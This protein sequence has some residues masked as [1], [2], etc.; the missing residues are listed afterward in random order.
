MFS[1]KFQ[2]DLLHILTTIKN[3][4]REM[5]VVKKIN[6]KKSVYLILRLKIMLVT[7]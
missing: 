5:D 7:K 1:K 6:K 4:V 3:N 2:W